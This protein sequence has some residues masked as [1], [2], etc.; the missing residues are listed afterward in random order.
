MILILTLGF[1]EKFQ[2]R[3]LMRQGKNVD[4]VIIIGGF[5]EEKAKK[6]LESLVN[7]LRTVNVPFEIVEVDPRDFENVIEN[8]GK[9]IVNN[10]G[11]DF[12][13]NLSGG[14]RLM[15]LAVFSAFLL[16]GID[17]TIEIETEDLTKVYY[18][19]VS[20][21]TSPS[22]FLTK[23]HLTILKAIKDGYSSA[24]MIS[25]TTGIPLTTTWRRLNELRKEKFID[26]F[27]KL[28]IK[29]EILLKIYGF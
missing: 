25:K 21:V 10:A 28:T 14:M 4:K 8:V 12:M 11:K 29:G 13:V 22:L 3:A 26:E 7:F 17:A 1:D 6:A 2:Y 16:T 15:I 23:A 20:D 19:R 9:V 27:N 18:F 24:N 5:E